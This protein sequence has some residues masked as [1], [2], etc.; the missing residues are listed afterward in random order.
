MSARGL[1]FNAIRHAGRQQPRLRS[2][3]PPSYENRSAFE[4]YRYDALGRRVLVRTRSEF[5]CTQYCLNTLRRIVWDGDQMLYE[6]SAPGGTGETAARMEADTGLAVPF[7][8]NDQHTAISG[9]FPYGRVMYEHGGGI[10]AP[11]GVV[12]MEFSDELK[13]PQIVLP[14]ANWR[15][16]YD[17][18]YTIGSCFAYGS[19][20]TFIA[21]PVDGTPSTAD[22]TRYPP[23]SG[24]YDGDQYHC[25]DV[26]WPAS[27]TYSALQY[28]RGYS[29]PDSWMGSL[30]FDNRDASGL[31]YRR[32]RYYDSEKGR[33]TQEDPI[34]LAGGVNVYG[35]ADG[36]PVSFADPLGLCGGENEICGEEEVQ[37]ADASRRCP[38]CDDTNP[39][40]IEWEVD[41]AQHATARDA[42]AAAIFLTVLFAPEVLPALGDF[43]ASLLS[44]GAV[45]GAAAIGAVDDAGSASQE[46]L[47]EG[48]QLLAIVN[49]GNV[50]TAPITTSHEQFVQ[51]V[52]NGPLPMGAW[53]G[54]LFKANGVITAMN[55]RSVVGNQNVAPFENVQQL[56]TVFK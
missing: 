29:G 16:S 53:T 30:L 43:G 2:A 20:G 52:F 41:R 11:L 5:A 38:P 26:D 36:D 24:G 6:I 14:L 19:N 42:V 33:F 45:G 55:S 1:Y 7:F 54:T 49:D 47:P 39:R 12:R 51:R 35:F 18:G 23:G 10:D 27:Y 22:T 8:L 28:R 17:R 13:A 32:E 48:A 15:G 50:W 40:Q 56:R 34:G 25:V 3:A 21:P 46:L 31:Y 37:D 9:F 4:E 44:G